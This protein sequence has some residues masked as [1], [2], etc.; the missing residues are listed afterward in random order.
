MDHVTQIY[1][2]EKDSFLWIENYWLA[3]SPTVQSIMSYETLS[4]QVRGFDAREQEVYNAFMLNLKDARGRVNGY[5]I[6]PILCVLV[7][8]LSVYL[9]NLHTK[10]RNKQLGR[11]NVKPKGFM[12]WM[13][14]LIPILLGLFALLYNSVFAIYMLTGQVVS[15]ILLPLQ[16]YIVDKF[17]NKKKA[18]QDAQNTVDYSRKF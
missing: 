18:M 6:L 9:N 10:K 3:D 8:A 1:D 13:P 17:T 14:I 2:D 11:E 5:Y 7:S 12:K 16:L 4:S 15:T